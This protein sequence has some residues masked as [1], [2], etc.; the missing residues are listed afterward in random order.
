MKEYPKEPNTSLNPEFAKKLRESENVL[1]YTLQ[2]PFDKIKTPKFT[3]CPSAESLSDFFETLGES[4]YKEC[5]YLFNQNNPNVFG[6]KTAN[7]DDLSILSTKNAF[8]KHIFMQDMILSSFDKLRKLI[9]GNIPLTSYYFTKL[10]NYTNDDNTPLNTK[11]HGLDYLT[12]ATDKEHLNIDTNENSII[13]KESLSAICSTTDLSPTG[14]NIEKN[15]HNK[16]KILKD[17]SLSSLTL[18]LYDE[19]PIATDDKDCLLNLNMMEFFQLIL[20]R[21]KIEE[22]QD[23]NT[24]PDKIKE[25]QGFNICPI[26]NIHKENKKFQFS[27]YNNYIQCVIYLLSQCKIESLDKYIACEMIEPI[28]EHNLSLSDKIYLRYQIEKI[29]APIMIDSM[30]QNIANTI[31]THNALNDQATINRL[32][33]CFSLPNVFTRHYIF[34]MAVDTLTKHSDEGFGDSYF[35]QKYIEVPT[36]AMTRVYNSVDPFRPH[37][38]LSIWLERYESFVKY[39]SHMLMPVY[40]NLYFIKLWHSIRSTYPENN[41]AECIVALYKLLR[42]YLN[43]EDCVQKLLSTEETFLEKEENKEKKDK[44]NNFLPSFFLHKKKNISL[45]HQCILSQNITSK[46]EAIPE[47]LSLKYLN[48]YAPNPTDNIQSFYI[49]SFMN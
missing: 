38:A 13:L 31:H 41:E 17:F 6:S 49:R 1:Q 33:S 34:Q 19:E 7:V 16:F 37:N 29:F 10:F 14:S 9:G 42:Q 8:W 5:S 40:E 22:I 11:I 46:Q 26:I 20:S 4:I 48:Q 3:D 43:N 28:A 39:L 45:Y 23:F 27:H 44:K 12:G 15:L 18:N 21:R 30:Y 35:F 2:L 32:S 24:C 25:I 47:F 36:A